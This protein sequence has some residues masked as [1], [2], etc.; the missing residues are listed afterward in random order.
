MGVEQKLHRRGLETNLQNKTKNKSTK[1]C[2]VRTQGVGG[3]AVGGVEWC[4]S[5]RGAAVGAAPTSGQ[6]DKEVA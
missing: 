2:V 4:G 5:S 6:V 3:L 1:T